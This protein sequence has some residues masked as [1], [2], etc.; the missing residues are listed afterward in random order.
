MADARPAVAAPP[1]RGLAAE[2]RAQDASAATGKPGRDARLDVFRGLAL[3]TIYINHVPGTIFE[4]LTSRNFGFSDAAEAFVIMS[5]VAAG[6]AYGPDLAGSRFWRGLRRAWGRAWTLYMVHITTTVMAV[7]IAAAAARFFGV[8]EMIEINNVAQFFD[9]QIGVLIGLPT[10]GHQI[11]YFNILPLYVTLLLATPLLVR[12]G[13]ARPMALILGSVA[14]WFAAGIVRLN[15]PAYP[16]PGGWFFNP[17]AWQLI[18]VMGLLTG[19]AMRR[20]ERLVPVRPWLVWS[21]A[22]FLLAVLAWRLVPPVAAA[23]RAGAH[24]LYDMGLPFNVVGFD[25][26]FLAAP[27]ALHALALF[28]LVTALPS[29]RRAASAAWARPVALMG[30]QAL[31]VFATGSVLCILGQSIL[32]G[33]PESFVLDVWVI[34]GGLLIQLAMAWSFETLSERRRAA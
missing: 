19:L 12:L 11:G 16:N 26:T 15:L 33:L 34:V 25:K 18:F 27:R 28:Y 22:A 10:L 32:N 24:A 14:L 13:H 21:C 23:G 9:D 31:P 6:I 8:P 17:F 1:V 20:G 5:G 30:R 29:V 2:S 7:G 4:H 3:V